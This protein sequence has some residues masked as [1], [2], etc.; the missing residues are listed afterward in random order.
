MN[1]AFVKPAV[2]TWL[3]GVLLFLFTALSA[4][5]AY[6]QPDRTVSGTVTDETGLTVIGAAVQVSGTSIGAITDIDGKFSLDVP[7]GTEQLTVSCVGFVTENVNITSD[8]LSIVLRYI[9]LG[10]AYAIWSGAGIVLVSLVGRFVY[11]QH[12]DTAAIIGICMIIAGV[13][14]INLFSKSAGH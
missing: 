12:L 8:L 10:I 13:L 6:A 2:Q 14:V 1:N 7:S 4:G 3:A 11:R 5:T 9:P